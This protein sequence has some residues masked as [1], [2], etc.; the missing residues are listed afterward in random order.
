MVSALVL[1]GG[2]FR[3]MLLCMVVALQRDYVG[4]ALVLCC[5]GMVSALVRTMV[6]ALYYVCGSALYR[7][8]G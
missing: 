4:S 6:S 5:Y 7:G 2:C 8:Y 1:C 3:A